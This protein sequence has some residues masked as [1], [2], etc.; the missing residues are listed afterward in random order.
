[1]TQTVDQKTLETVFAGEDR[2]TRLARDIMARPYIMGKEMSQEQYQEL[3][4]FATTIPKTYLDQNGRRER[5][6]TENEVMYLVASSMKWAI[7]NF[8]NRGKS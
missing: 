3:L 7:E 5:P 2:M 4:N 6:L 8:T 1:M